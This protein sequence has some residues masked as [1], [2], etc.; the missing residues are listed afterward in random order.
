[1][2][3]REILTQYS[4]VV[5]F[6][7]FNGSAS[8]PRLSVFCSGKQLYAMLVDDQ[9]KKTLFYGSTLQKSIRQDLLCST[10]VST[11]YL[12]FIYFFLFIVLVLFWIS[13]IN[14]WK[15]FSFCNSMNFMIISNVT[16]LQLQSHTMSHLHRLPCT[17]VVIGIVL[18]HSIHSL[19]LYYALL[20][21][22][23]KSNILSE[24]DSTRVYIFKFIFSI[25]SKLTKIRLLVTNNL[26]VNYMPVVIFFHV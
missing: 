12:F 3:F 13:I 26:L 18:I 11:M 17:L 9:N 22:R 15:L 6:M 24:Y 1:M 25:F 16:K 14:I 19:L 2:P 21:F 20:V 23:W 5:H 7:Q 8:K 10:I 4:P